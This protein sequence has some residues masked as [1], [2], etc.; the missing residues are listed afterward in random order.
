MKLDVPT[1]GTL[2]ERRAADFPDK[3]YLFFEDKRWSYGQLDK[4]VDRLAFGLARA[5]IGKETHVNVHL[6]NRPEFVILFFALAKLGAVM[7]PTN[8]ALREKELGYILNHADVTVGVTEPT[9]LELYAK[10]LPACPNVKI[11]IVVGADSTQA[12]PGT[13]TLAWADVTNSTGRAPSVALEGSDTALIMYT[14]GTTALPK[15]AMISHQN[16]LSAGHSWMW[17]VG[18]TAKDRTMTGLPLF[19]ANAL[20]FSCVGSMVYGGSFVLLR[21]FSPSRYLQL[22]SQYGATH[23]NFIG[24]AMAIMLQQPPATSDQQHPV[25]VVHDA[26]GTP[27]LIEEWSRRFEIAVVMLYNLT[28]CTIATGT[29]ISGPQPV[30]LGSIGWPAPSLPF[31]TEVRVLDEQGRDTP[32]GVIGEIVVRGPALMK[33]YYKDPDKTAEAVRDGWLHTGDAGYRDEDGCFWFADR[34]KDMIKPKGE[35]V[36]SAE[37]EATIASHPRVADVGIIGVTDP[38]TGEEIK[39][40]ILLKPDETAETVPPEEILAWCDERLASFKVPRFIEYRTTPLPR[41]L[42]GAKILKREIR[43]EKPNP[44]EGCYDR[45]KRRWVE[46]K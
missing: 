31:R 26:I 38:I 41:T 15:G 20:F 9:F 43:K 17:L 36:S 29:P 42:G 45:R 35:N 10:I 13:R 25:R 39:A 46:V 7:I 6:S 37:V 4:E 18:F 22:A 27:E 21:G 32:P 14:S 23:F 11:L 44:I 5:G 19:H 1:L 12:P 30:K 24:P 33:G 28:E 2:L 16:V 8:L 34:I 3:P 40:S